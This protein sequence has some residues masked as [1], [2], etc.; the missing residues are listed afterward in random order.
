MSTS[1]LDLDILSVFLGKAGYL[2]VVSASFMA[3][4]P[5]WEVV[6]R[7][8]KPANVVVILKDTTSESAGFNQGSCVSAG[9]A[10]CYLFPSPKSLCLVSFLFRD[11]IFI[12]QNG[13]RQCGV[14]L[15]LTRV[16]M[17][18]WWVFAKKT[19]SWLQLHVYQTGFRTSYH[20]TPKTI[21][22]NKPTH[23]YINNSR[24]WCFS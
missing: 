6:R 20:L 21:P 7:M 4:A 2:S 17:I 8:A 14:L 9:R 19:S 12:I 3:M 24:P 1:T 11:F 15:V 5:C 22:L 18:Q 16:P 23:R 13:K 10:R